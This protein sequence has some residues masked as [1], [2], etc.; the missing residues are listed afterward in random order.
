MATMKPNKKYYFTVEGE[1]EQ[2]YLQWLQKQI[3]NDATS[4]FTV[5]LDCPIQKSPL[6]R[7]KTLII[8]T[9][10]TKKTEITHLFDRESEEEVHTTEF[11]K[12]LDE[13]K[14]AE[15]LGK[16]IKYKLGYSNFAFELWMVLHKIG[17]NGSLMHRSHYLTP[18][19][20]AYGESF[21]NLEQ[22]KQKASFHRVL[23]K[24][25]LSDVKDAI[26]RSRGIIQTNEE[27]GYTLHE[28]KGY[29]YYKE[30]PALSIWEA[31]EEILNDCGL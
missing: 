31:I 8:T 15:R 21:L 9:G 4:K 6:K 11:Q 10:V 1:T 27:N 24:L 14:S 5:K 22:Y 12:T 2:W 28:Y 23:G 26:N 18:I 29:K 13:M 30:N 3:N 7:A 20:R 25:T 19:N 17:C 16:K